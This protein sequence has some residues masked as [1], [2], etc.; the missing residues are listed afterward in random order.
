M[1]E[2]HGTGV[3]R[4]CSKKV[5]FHNI[6]QGIKNSLMKLILTEG[7][8]SILLQSH[9]TLEII[10]VDILIYSS[11]GNEGQIQSSPK[12]MGRLSY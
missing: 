5:T 10:A 8:L 4:W 1:H 2:S 7:I 6:F 11:I 3:V 9:N 12:S